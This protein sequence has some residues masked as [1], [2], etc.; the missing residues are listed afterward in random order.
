MI[1]TI[2]GVLVLIGIVTLCLRYNRSDPVKHCEVYKNE[3]CIHVDGLLCNYPHCDIREQ[4]V[5]FIKHGEHK[6]GVD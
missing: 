1:E 2:L 5:Y 3:G 4:Y 6:D